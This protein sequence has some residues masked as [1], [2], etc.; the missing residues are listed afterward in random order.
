MG[1]AKPPML[2]RTASWAVFWRQFETVAEHNCWTR[3]QKSTYFITTLKH[4]AT[5]VLQG[6]LKGMSYEE[7]LET[8]K[9]CFREQHLAAAYRSQQKRRTQGVGEY[10]QEFATAVEQ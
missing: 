9:D 7:T 10:L 1:V 5:N 6:V 3:L 4:C 8:P 2:D